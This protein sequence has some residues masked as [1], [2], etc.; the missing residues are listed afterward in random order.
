MNEGGT[1]GRD[2][3]YQGIITFRPPSTSS[4]DRPWSSYYEPDGKQKFDST[5][6]RGW[7]F[8]GPQEFE[9]KAKILESEWRDKPLDWNAITRIG[10]EM[11]AR[12]K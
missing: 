10:R 5:V 6:E 4:D 7:N 9:Y 1:H 2:D 3:L 11:E 12:H 8:D